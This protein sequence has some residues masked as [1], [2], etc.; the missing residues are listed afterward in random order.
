MRVIKNRSNETDDQRIQ[1]LE[2][3]RLPVIENRSNESAEQRSNRQEL[4]R[5][6][7]NNR[8]NETEEEQIQRRVRDY[9]RHVKSIY[10]AIGDEFDDL[11]MHQSLMIQ[12]FMIIITD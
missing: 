10:D 1:R 4:E 3:K 11:F 8:W 5:V 9:L 6:R 12:I 7:V 2:Q